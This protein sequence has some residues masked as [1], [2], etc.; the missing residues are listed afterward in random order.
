MTDLVTQHADSAPREPLSLRLDRRSVIG[1]LQV[2]IRDD[3]RYRGTASVAGCEDDP[4]GCRL[5]HR[6][7]VP[8]TPRFDEIQT[9][10]G[11][12]SFHL[13]PGRKTQCL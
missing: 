5:G 2:R 6:R 8:V 10:L 4:F 3:D 1:R 9:G 11:E 7:S 13:L 12:A